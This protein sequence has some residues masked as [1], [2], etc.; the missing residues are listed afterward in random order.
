MSSVFHRHTAMNPPRAV[1]GNGCYIVA[2]DG[3]RYL[4]A[5]GGAAV[6]CLGHGDPDVTAAIKTQLDSIAFAHTGFFTSEPAEELA[7]LLAAATH[8][9]GRLF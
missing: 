5:S 4:D 6:S 3:K 2:D 1:A 7:A 9:S 8:I